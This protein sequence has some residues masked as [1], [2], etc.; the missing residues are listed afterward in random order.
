[1]AQRQA[2]FKEA[3]DGYRR[4]LA[5]GAPRE[6]VL[7]ALTQLYFQTNR[8]DD[9]AQCLRDLI[10]ATPG[11]LAYYD[12]L[13]QLHER[14]GQVKEAA[15]VYKALLARAPTLAN[16]WFNLA[17]LQK[18]M[19]Q[20]DEALASYAEALRRGIDGPEEVHLNRGVI[21]ADC[22]MQPDW[23]EKELAQALALNPRYEPALLNL[24][25]LQEERGAKEE[26]LATYGKLLGAAPGHAEALARYA[27]LRGVP[28]PEDP[29]VYRLKKAADNPS[30]DLPG[31]TS[32]RFALGKVLDGCGAYD[33]AFDQYG[34]ANQLSRQAGASYDR[35]AQERLT[36]AL[37]TTFSA[38]W[39]EGLTPVSDASPV[40][41]CGMFRSGST[42]LEQ[43]LAAHDAIT[44][45]GELDFWADTVRTELSPFPATVLHMAE[46]DRKMLADRYEALIERL[47]PGARLVTDKRPD[48]FLYVGLIK[49]L[50][51]RARIIHTRR[52]VLDNCL[53]VYFLHLGASMGYATDLLDTG[54]YWREQER[55]MDHW[56]SLFEDTITSFDYDAFVKAPESELR[57]LLGFLGLDWDDKCLSFHTL[58]NVVKTASYWQVRQPLYKSSSGRWHNYERHLGP[59]RK[60]LGVEGD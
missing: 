54:H 28:S 56:K 4:L 11:Q 51:P 49:S 9:A 33:A 52:N 34:Q 36:D 42:L 40:F 25:N 41:I 32:L 7:Q 6:P 45:G 60:I 44:A 12:H 21:Y 5:E 24:A 55:L 13:I 53:S 22:L 59:L 23:A 15:G 16:S 57:P 46:A 8:P 20:Y 10:K 37:I 35:Q 18:Q 31:K 38:D 50:F 17:R 26:A 27:N 29:L 1:M 47:Y 58:Q 30:T 19:R 14:M 48:N 2:R 39:F 3:E 43:V